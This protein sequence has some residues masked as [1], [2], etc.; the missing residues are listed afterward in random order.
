M[1][2]TPL[3]SAIPE[4]RKVRCGPT[5]WMRIGSPTAKP[6]LAAVAL[7]MATWSLPLGQEPSVSCVGLNSW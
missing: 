5:A 3:S 1:E 4:M 6:L 7:S 2:P